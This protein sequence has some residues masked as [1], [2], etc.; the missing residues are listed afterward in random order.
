MEDISARVTDAEV[1][2]AYQERTIEALNDVVR[3]FATR[4]EALERQVKALSDASGSA[5][6]GPALEKPPHY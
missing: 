2:L 3:E 4:V 6:I 1:R 5:A